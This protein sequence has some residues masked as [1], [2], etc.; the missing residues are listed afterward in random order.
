[1]KAENNPLLPLHEELEVEKGRAISEA[2]LLNYAKKWK[3]D[4]INLPPWVDTTR[5]KVL[6]ALW[7]YRREYADD[8]FNREHVPPS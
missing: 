7:R 6:M 8:F 3:P 4:G 5:E 1:M 2:Q